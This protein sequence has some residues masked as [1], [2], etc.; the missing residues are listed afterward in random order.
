[1]KKHMKSLK[2]QVGHKA[3]KIIKKKILKSAAR[4]AVVAVHTVV[5]LAV[6]QGAGDL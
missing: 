1:M 6:H 2:K 5:H 3:A 4:H